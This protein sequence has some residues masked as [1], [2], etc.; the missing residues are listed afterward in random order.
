ML[1]TELG[2]GGKLRVIPGENIARMKS[3]LALPE[4]ASYTRESLQRIRGNLGTD[5]VVLGSYTAGRGDRRDIRDSF[6]HWHGSKT[7]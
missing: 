3:D 7:F 6:Q 2:A 5:M 1:T 4:E